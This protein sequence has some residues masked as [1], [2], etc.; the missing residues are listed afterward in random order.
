MVEKL[1]ASN[2]CAKKRKVYSPPKDTFSKTCE[3]LGLGGTC[4]FGEQ[5]YKNYGDDK[6]AKVNANANVNFTFTSESLLQNEGKLLRRF[7]RNYS[8][9]TFGCLDVV[10][11]FRLFHAS[12]GVLGIQEF[13]S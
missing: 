11:V 1:S 8:Y 2:R 4:D 12:S 6:Y 13:K 10:G 9:N 3:N 5:S 7:I